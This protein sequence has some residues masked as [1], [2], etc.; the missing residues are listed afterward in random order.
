M[1]LNTANAALP[2]GPWYFPTIMASIMPKTHATIALP[3]AANRYLKYVGLILHLSRSISASGI[4]RPV[5]SS[6]T[7]RTAFYANFQL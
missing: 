5:I 6:I 3:D 4:K 2:T 1:G 7:G